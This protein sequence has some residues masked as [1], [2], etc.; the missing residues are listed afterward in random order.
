M[1]D[2]KLRASASAS[3]TGRLHAWMLPALM[4]SIA[5]P[6]IRV[7]HLDLPTTYILL[8]TLL[9][10]TFLSL[11]WPSRLWILRQLLYAPFAR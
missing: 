4:L 2:V 3:L 6:S 9:P 11:S 8:A 10:F 5:L 1:Q 7:G